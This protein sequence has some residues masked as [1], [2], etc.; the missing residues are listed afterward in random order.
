MTLSARETSLISGKSGKVCCHVIVV[1][2]MVT[3]VLHDRRATASLSKPS[4][5]KITWRNT[6]FKAPVTS[7]ELICNTY[8][9]RPLSQSRGAKLGRSG[10]RRK[11]GSS[12]QIYGLFYLE[13]PRN[14]KYETPTR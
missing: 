4:H 7:I 8:H 6:R 14:P 13:N 1:V 12:V 9:I 10:K 11:S 3:N 2:L 5:E